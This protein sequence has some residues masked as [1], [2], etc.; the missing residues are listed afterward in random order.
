MEQIFESNEVSEFVKAVNDYCT[1]VENANNFSKKDFLEKSLTL[2]PT[3]YFYA[4]A[5][6]ETEPSSEEP[7]QKIVTEA[8]WENIDRMVKQKLGE[9]NE[10]LEVF[11][12]EMQESEQPIIASLAENFADIYQDL[13]DF[14]TIY[15]MGTEEMMIDALWE[16]KNNFRHLWGQHLTNALRALHNVF[17]NEDIEEEDDLID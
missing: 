12:E 15:G 9:H 10:Y 11:R 3:L 8:D 5:I 14:I 6:P 2:L 7:N 17:Y 4:T 16:C 13:K 1:L